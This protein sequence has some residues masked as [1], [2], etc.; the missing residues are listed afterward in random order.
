MGPGLISMPPM[1]S[2]IDMPQ[3]RIVEKGIYVA[4]CQNRSVEQPKMFENLR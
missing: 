3:A 4:D 1:I 2:R